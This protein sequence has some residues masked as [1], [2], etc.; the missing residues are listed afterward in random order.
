MTECDGQGGAAEV[1]C[2]GWQLWHLEFLQKLLEDGNL[3]QNSTSNCFLLSKCSSLRWL[4]LLWG[5]PSKDV[6]KRKSLWRTPPRGV[7]KR[8]SCKGCCWRASQRPWSYV[9]RYLE[10]SQRSKFVDGRYPEASQRKV[11][12]KGRHQRTSQRTKFS[13]LT[14]WICLETFPTSVWP[15][16]FWAW[17]LLIK[18]LTGKISAFFMFCS[19]DFKL[20][21]YGI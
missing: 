19:L 15:E 12:C 7:L 8:W 2:C 21:F 17:S 14:S 13:L 16:I 6:P 9:G 5:T 3:M 1:Q 20:G 11:S 4:S 10:A 18:L